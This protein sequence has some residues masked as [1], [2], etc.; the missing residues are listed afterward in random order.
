MLNKQT[1]EEL[2]HSIMDQLPEDP[3]NLRKEFE[4]NL[5]SALLASL[6]KMELVTREEFD[7]QTAVLARTR[8][9]LEE[10][11]HKVATLEQQQQ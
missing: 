11:E 3:G 9:L 6:K 10:L 5:K 4:S 1:I 8:A 2:I 7:V